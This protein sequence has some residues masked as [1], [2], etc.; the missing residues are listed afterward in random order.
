[1]GNAE[2]LWRCHLGL[3]VHIKDKTVEEIAAVARESGLRYLEIV[4]ERFW[5]LPDGGAETRWQE[6]KDLLTRYHLRPIVHS[7]YIDINMASLNPPL[8]EAALRQ[9]LR[10]LEFAIF[11]EAEHLVVHPGNLNRNYP[12]S[13]LPEARECLQK[14]LKSL[15][16]QAESARMTVALENGWNGENHPLIRNGDEHAT[17][18]ESVGSPALKALFDV[19]HANTFGVDLS[20]YSDRLQAYL[21]GIHLH[22]NGGRKDEHLPLGR[23]TIHRADFQRCFDAGVPVV[24]EMNSLNDIST[25]LAYLEANVTSA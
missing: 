16:A 11:L 6:I 2:P 17:L 24:L 8:R 1:M 14:S 9:N 23:G 15:T 3:S 10:C 18:I 22:D 20:A 13:S 25:S 5:D 4:A 7:S 19:G 12:A 21:V